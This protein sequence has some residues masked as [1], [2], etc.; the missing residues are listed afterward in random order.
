MS[1]FAQ[2][3]RWKYSTIGLLAV[4]AVVFS[5]PQAFAHVSNNTADMLNHIYQF[6]DGIEAKTDNL[7]SDPASST[8]VANAQ[9]NINTNSNAAISNAVSDIGRTKSV[10][11]NV[12]FDIDGELDAED[13]F[14]VIPETTDKT[15]SGHIS[16][17]AT[18]MGINEDLEVICKLADSTINI[19]HLTGPLVVANED[20]ACEKLTIRVQT[21]PVSVATG[22]IYAVTQYVGSSGVTTQTS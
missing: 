2:N 6:V 20:F 16:L 12:A 10:V 18:G 7:P 14:I 11:T 3:S 4:L 15:F 13:S 9:N 8:D 22:N 21:I 17:R 19:V 5:F 1:R